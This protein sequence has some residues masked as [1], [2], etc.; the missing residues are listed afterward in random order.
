MSEPFLREE[1]RGAV[2]LLT[3]DGPEDRNAL[4]SAGQ[5]SEF[6]DACRRINADREVKAVILTGRDPAFCSGGN[7]KHMRSLEGFMAGPVEDVAEGYRATLQQMA[8]ALH[9]LEVPLIAAV[10]GPAIGAGLDI[11][12]MCDI[13]IASD[14]AR[15]AEAFV[16]LGLISGIGG[17]WFLP[18]AVGA[19]RAA[20]LSFTARVFDA[21]EALK[22]G[23]VSE[24]LPADE[25]MPRAISL[26]EEIAQHPATALRFCKRLLRMAEMAD[27]GSTLDATA[28]LQAV[29]HQ[30]HEHHAAVERFLQARSR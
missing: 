3:M 5:C 18:R 9:G 6:V 27:L 7:I 1:R 2:T 13:R 15:F 29:A 11:A 26:A 21:D 17:A 12:C 30:T 16:R 23:L 19:S 8:R 4:S 14:S 22:Y 28:A 10:N 25:L 24:V 20:E